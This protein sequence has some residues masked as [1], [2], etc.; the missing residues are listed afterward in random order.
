MLKVPVV[1]AKVLGVNVY[2]G[3]A[4]LGDLAD[5]SKADIYDQK[6][7]PTGTQRDLSPGHAR[8]A[9]GYVKNRDL[10]FWPE[11]FL[12]ARKKD[13]MTFYPVSA[14]LPDLGILEIDTA[15][16]AKGS[17]GIAISRIDGNHR[18]QYGS[19]PEPVEK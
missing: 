18:L 10:G 16:A 1:R 4:K 15:A 9:Y 6:N 14:K 12:C 7:N 11:V 2:R 8:D 3:F 17:K 13:V 5:I 19:A